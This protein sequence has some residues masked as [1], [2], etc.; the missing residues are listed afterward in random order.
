MKIRGVDYDLGV[1]Y[2]RGISSRPTFDPDVA[3]REIDIIQD[4]LH[5][6]AIRLNGHDIQR[7]LTA[8]E[9]ALER[10]LQVWVLPKYV[11]ATQQD[12]LPYLAEYARAAESLRQKSAQVVFV[13]GCEYTFFLNGILEGA[14]ILERLGNPSNWERMRRGEHN[15][16][17]NEFLTQAVAEI[18][19]YFHG[20]LTYASIPL[21]KVDWSLFDYI[22]LDHYREARNRNTYGETL[23]RYREV[24]K[25][26]VV[27]E[28]GCCAYKGAE[29]QG[30]RGWM[31]VDGN[32]N[33]PRLNTDLVRDESVQASE[34]T[35]MLRIVDSAGAEGAFVYTFTAPTHPY[36]ADPKYDLD[37]ANYSLVKNYVDRMGTT[38]HHLPWDPKEAFGAVAAYYSD[39][40]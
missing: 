1:E 21:E 18:R 27:T 6:N 26:L 15:Q 32:A 36:N 24:G 2:L 33:P 13:A 9:Y 25:P 11:D 10:G 37:M 38:Y 4:D 14:N 40:H 39:Q 16:P 23:L 31:V 12:I 29:D 8:G 17:L 35:D 5:C 20:P 19:R 28:L 30:G 7:M 22:G 34:I 3:K